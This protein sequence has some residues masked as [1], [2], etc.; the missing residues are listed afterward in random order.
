MIIINIQYLC[1][2]IGNLSG[3]P[4]R[5]YK[6]EELLLSCSVIRFP[7]DPMMPYHD[8]IFRIS[9]HVSY[10]VTPHFMYY[11]ILNAEDLKIVIG[12]TAQVLPSDQ[13]LRE[14]AFQADVPK[15]DTAAFLEGFKALR[16]MPLESLLMMLCAVNHVLTGEE[17][18]LGDLEIHE[19]E[20]QRIKALV[21]QRRAERKYNA[22]P[23]PVPNNSIQV[24]EKLLSIVR[25]GDTAVLRQWISQAPS[26]QSGVLAADQLRQLKNT[27]IVTATLVS[28]AAIQGGLSAEDALTLSDGFIRQV[29]LL[30]TQSAIFNLQ[31]NMVLEYTEQVEKIR[32]GSK[33]T[34]LV[35]EVANY[36]QHHLSEPINTEVMAREFYLSRTHF[37]AR[38]KKETGETLT[39]FILREKMEEAMR[40]LR[41]TDK[42]SAA[43][44]AYLGYSS[45]G[46]F[47]RVFKQ[48]T[49]KTPMEYRESC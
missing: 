3:L 16:L 37:S 22:D 46:H 34:K 39:A 10:F 26:V 17:L 24:E 38:F 12:P 27:F 40:L 9:S 6:G 31:Y 1:Q 11:G 29:E 7:R 14:L 18:E 4:V 19:A 23:T 41:Y 8:E 2:I 49:G 42:S 13:S 43:I 36:V 45:Q 28:R 15:D 44:G 47:A 20:Q 5:L 30:N 48:Y 21:E 32:R 33:P 25:S 35:L